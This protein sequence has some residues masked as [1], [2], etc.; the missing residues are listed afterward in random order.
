MADP[1]RFS[2]VKKMLEQAG[3]RLT[4]VRGSHHIFEKPG[5]AEHINIPVHG[6]EEL[7]CP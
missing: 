5:E 7:L 2:K 3:Y 6:G 4:R 1:E